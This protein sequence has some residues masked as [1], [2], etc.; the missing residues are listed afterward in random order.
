MGRL[1]GRKR[2]HVGSVAVR[3]WTSLLAIRLGRRVVMWVGLAVR[4]LVRGRRRGGW[5]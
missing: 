4:R 2:S 5:W 1:H 3:R